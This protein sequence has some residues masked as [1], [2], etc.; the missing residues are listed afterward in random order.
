MVMSYFQCTGPDIKSENFY[1]T[2]REK[3]IDY[4]SVDGFF[5]YCRS[6]FEAMGC[7]YHFFACQEFRPSLTEG[8][9]KRGSKKKGLDELRRG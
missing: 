3:K 2:G 7:F 5:A 6:V 9:I 4:F 1:T 8:D